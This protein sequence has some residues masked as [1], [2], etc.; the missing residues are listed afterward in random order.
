MS[1]Y[2]LSPAGFQSAPGRILEGSVGSLTAVESAV[3]R[4]GATNQCNVVAVRRLVPID[5][6]PGPD[7]VDRLRRAWD[8]G[9]AVLPVDPRLP[10]TAAERLLGAMRLDEPVENGDALVVATS[11]TTGEPKGVVLTHGAVRA[12]AVA[13]S[14]RLGVDPERDTWLACLP[15]AHVGGLSVVT[16]AIVTGTPLMVHAGF[17]ADAVQQAAAGGATLVSLVATALRR[18]DS[19][20]FRLIVLGGAAPPAEL[21]PNV[22]TTYGM[23]ETGSGVVYDGLALD[24]V[25]VAV[26]PSGEIA[27]RGAMLLRCY[28]DGTDPKD[29]D[30]WF[31][32]G[33]VGALD[34]GRLRVFGRVDDVI[35]SGGENVWPDAVEAVLL[36]LASVRE[37]A[38]V[39]R[40]DDEW[41]QRVV[42][43]VVPADPSS[44]PT[45]DELRATVK[46]H[47]GPW[48]APRELELVESLP[49]TVLGKIRRASV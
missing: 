25:D 31:R 43:V 30:G 24:G 37:V 47:L 5:L 14:A 3:A 8:G 32:T 17:D 23:T 29:A 40:D 1:L 15:L 42:A 18:I 38:V 27:V 22:V 13:T 12:S 46:D 39:G 34:D 4:G 35:I 26:D 20:R 16:R 33:D 10:R 9:D 36:L 19:T 6:P 21:P 44:P 49:R 45:L 7:F 41:G 48:A 2:S 11:G 28:R